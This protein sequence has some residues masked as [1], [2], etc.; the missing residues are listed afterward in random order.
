MTFTGREPKYQDGMVICEGTP[1]VAEDPEPKPKIRWVENLL[2]EELWE[3]KEPTETLKGHFRCLGK[4][5]RK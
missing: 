5:G 2:T 4:S 3:L 1:G